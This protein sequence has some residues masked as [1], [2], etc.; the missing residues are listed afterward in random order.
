MGD[1]SDFVAET[2]AVAPSSLVGVFESV[3]ES[4]NRDIFLS[5]QF[6]E[7]TEAV[8]QA[9]KDA[10][11]SVNEDYGLEAIGLSLRLRRID[12]ISSGHS[13]TI[14]ERILELIDGAGLLI[15][16]LTHGNINVYHEVGLMMGLN[17]ARGFKQSNFVLIVDE[18]KTADGDIGFNLRGWQQIRFRDTLELKN[19]VA[20]SLAVFYE[21]TGLE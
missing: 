5:M 9:I 8:H 15:A 20:A 13:F 7:K 21:L 14:D 6:G 11:R 2:Q 12:R 18:S 10:V 3:L 17:R 4:R 1:G 16:D 19:R